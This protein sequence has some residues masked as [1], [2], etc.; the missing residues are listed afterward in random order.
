MDGQYFYVFQWHRSFRKMEIFASISKKVFS[1]C[2]FCI[3]LQLKTAIHVTRIDIYIYFK[4]PIDR[5]YF[6]GCPINAGCCLLVMHEISY[7]VFINE[8]H[9]L[10][11]LHII[12]T[13]RIRYLKHFRKISESNILQNNLK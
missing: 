13:N 2:H 11:L 1:D 12:R 8:V 9:K 7:D 3:F 10:D 6:S 5:L 4:Y